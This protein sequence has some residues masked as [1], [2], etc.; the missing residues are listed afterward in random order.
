M[1]SS[2]TNFV[3]VITTNPGSQTSPL[4]PTTATTPGV[5]I[6]WSKTGTFINT[7]DTGVQTN[8]ICQ[9]SNTLSLDGY[10]ANSKQTSGCYFFKGT[11]TFTLSNPIYTDDE[12]DLC[13]MYVIFP[14][15]V[16][17][18]KTYPYNSNLS[19]NVECSMYNLGTSAASPIYQM[20][21]T[22]PPTPNPKSVLPTLV[23][24]INKWFAFRSPGSIYQLCIHGYTN[25][26][27]SLPSGDIANSCL[28]TTST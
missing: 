17:I 2:I 8:F 18:G 1:S 7:T 19:F 26:L 5:C 10:D 28:C 11:V 20:T 9:T 27:C 14:S 16:G 4:D 22:T 23:V 21:S 25:T 24:P 3:N 6:V 13:L 12:N 15:T